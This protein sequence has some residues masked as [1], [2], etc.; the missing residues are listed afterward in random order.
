MWGI[1]CPSPCPQS[2]KQAAHVFS[3][4]LAH[5]SPARLERDHGHH[6]PTLPSLRLEHVKPGTTDEE[7]QRHL[8]NWQLSRLAMSPASVLRSCDSCG[9]GGESAEIESVKASNRSKIH[10]G[11]STAGVRGG[12]ADVS[13]RKLTSSS[14]S[15]T[16]MILA[17]PSIKLLMISTSV[18]PMRVGSRA[19]THCVRG[20]W[21]A[22]HA[23][24]PSPP[25]VHSP[26]RST[27]GL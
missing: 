2:R 24:L 23:A 1:L 17:T 3:I 19:P 7:F 5:P 11:Q 10:R 20:T 16:E 15:S 6:F 18:S 25:T 27:T 13:T 21:P 8:T 12:K 4:L 14:L 9:D 22:D 26:F